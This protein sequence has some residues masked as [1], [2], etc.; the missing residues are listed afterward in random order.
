MAVSRAVAEGGALPDTLDH[1]SEVAANL[2]RARAAAI[3][4]RSSE[5]DVGLA[6]A[7]SFRLTPQYA[8][9]LNLE[10]PLEVGH[11]PSGMAVK[12]RSP[13]AVADMQVDPIAA[14]WGESAPRGVPEHDLGPAEA[15]RRLRDR[16]PERLPTAA[17]PV[18]RQRGRAAA[19]ARRP[20][21]DRRPDGGAARRL[22][23]PG[24]RPLA[25]RALAARAGPRALESRSTRSTGCSPS[26]RSSRPGGSW[27]PSRRPTTPPTRT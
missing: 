18:G 13:V 12:S 25:P 11:G 16:R 8:A 1:I 5:W 27:A 9:Y 19:G 17:A 21:R 24:R 22:A 3:I 20:R 2:L 15:R 14:P 10:R 4:L 7:G 23:P 6:V 26:A